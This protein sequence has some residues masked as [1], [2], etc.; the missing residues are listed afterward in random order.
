M[1][2][3]RRMYIAACAVML[4]IP[5]TAVALATGQTVTDTQSAIAAK[6]NHHHVGYGGLVTVT[7]AASPA[8]P[9]QQVE[10]QFAR[11]GSR[12]WQEL[13]ASNVRRDGS[14]RLAAHLKRSGLVK[15]RGAE[16]SLS[17]GAA[18]LT[19][20]SATGASSAPQRVTVAAKFAIKT[21]SIVVL[22]GHAEALRGKLLPAIAGRRVRLEGREADGRWRRLSTART[23]TRGGFALRYVSG[24]GRQLRVRFAG[25]RANTRS[26]KPTGRV[27]VFQ[28]AIAAWYYDGGG[29]ACGFHARYGVANRDLPCGT[30]VTFRNGGNE[31]TATVDDRGPFV[32]GRTWDLSQST[33]GALG[34]A[35]IGAIWASR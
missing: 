25:D 10:L 17:G 31:V 11:A 30:Q 9:G 18:A 22:G 1:R 28:Q 21:R 6:L 35:G 32:A 33:A 34:F 7:G 3:S 13:A 2:A 5:A 4:A 14:F 15:V 12:R 29:T 8:Q 24:E 27:T 23:G 19:T 16:P 20:S 26:S